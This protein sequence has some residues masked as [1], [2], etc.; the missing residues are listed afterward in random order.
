MDPQPPNLQPIGPWGYSHQ[1]D[2]VPRNSTSRCKISAC[3]LM[4][5][6]CL[7]CAWPCLMD[8]PTCYFRK[9][10]SL[11]F[12]TGRRIRLRGIKCTGQ[13][14][15][16]EGHKGTSVHILWRQEGCLSCSLMYSLLS[17]QYQATQST[18]HKYLS[19]ESMVEELMTLSAV[20]F[21]PCRLK[22]KCSTWELRVKFY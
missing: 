9:L 14:H 10:T 6:E 8:G 12:Y 22:K 11:V 3:Q 4:T 19:S 16:A 2:G 18:V 13:D 20:L 21:G 15:P 7:E 17:G 5:S 1:L